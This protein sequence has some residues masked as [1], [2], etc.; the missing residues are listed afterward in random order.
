M[1]KVTGTLT[2]FEAFQRALQKAPDA[3]NDYA[4]DV[5][6]KSTFAVAQRARTFVPVRTGRLKRAIT[7]RAIKLRGRVGFSEKV[8]YWRFVEF[9]TVKRVSHPFIRPAVEAESESFIQGMRAIGPRLERDL[10]T[11]RL[12]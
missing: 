11:G 3:V 5:V 7:S 4:S 9:G 1:A 10:S 8:P 12:L 2:G 6:L